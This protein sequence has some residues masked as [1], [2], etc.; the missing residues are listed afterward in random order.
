[1]KILSK[2]FFRQGVPVPAFTIRESEAKPEI[3][4]QMRK[5]DA[6][7]KAAIARARVLAGNGA[8]DALQ[9]LYISDDEIEL[10]MKRQRGEMF[11]SDESIVDARIEFLASSWLSAIS[12][13]W[14]FPDFDNAV[15]I[16]A[17]APEL[18][19]R[20]ERIYA[21]LQDDVTK[22]RPTVDLALNLFCNGPQERL[23]RR[24]RFRSDAPLIRSGMLRLLPDPALVEPPL[25]AQYLRVGERAAR[26]LLGDNSLDS[27]LASFCAYHASPAQ[28]AD[29]LRQSD[30]V[31]RLPAFAVGARDNGRPIRLLF[32]GPATSGKR[33]AAAALAQSG[34]QAL[35]TADLAR[36][37]AW[38]NEPAVIASLLA[39]EAALSNGLLYVS[40]LRCS[41]PEEEAGRLFVDGLL[42]SIETVILAAET[43]AI[44]A[45]IGNERFLEIV[46]ALPD[47]EA[48]HELW[49]SLT[50]DAGITVDAETSDTL[51]SNFVLAPEEIAAA[52]NFAR[53][54]LDWKI[55]A[56]AGLEKDAAAAELLSAA[57]R[58][59]G[60][61][62]AAL[63]SKVRPVH[64]WEDIVLPEDALQQLKEISARVRFGHQVME[65][66]GF[67]RKL[68]SGKGI[69][70]L[71]A[72][73]SGTGKTMAAEV[74]ANDLNLDLYRIDLS[75]VVSKYIGE[76]EQNLERI[77]N[78]A[79]R[80]NSVLLF[81]EADSLLGKR[82]AVHDAH[83][84]YAN[85]EISYLLQKM[86]QHEGITI[87]TTNLRGNIDD[88]FLR[89]LAFMVQF[90]FPEE[91]ARLKIWKCVWPRETAV[92][93]A[94][95]FAALANRFRLSGGNISNV[96]LSAA[97]LAAEQARPVGMADILRATQREYAKV[98]KNLSIAELNEVVH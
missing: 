55:T 45:V 3:L 36:S 40:G 75:R 52:V 72:G 59:S 92:D 34:G 70:A 48:R 60:G 94:V 12:E 19:L 2:S 54:Q 76:T 69:A 43:S 8:D 93:R 4:V 61:E 17:L 38:K 23:D 51:A 1:M 49:R 16:L 47:Y 89:R 87:L 9:G 5:L 90:P 88:A 84:R 28:P 20:Y 25:L 86:E 50:E 10:L 58:Q 68:S 31:Q 91:E 57:R 14:S 83:D 62:L 35:L 42:E 27:R 26:A 71:F 32:S 11:D 29:T 21:Y 7:L 67:G 85:M 22:R 24:L 95:D 66:G 79:V 39:Q 44:S 80:S 46:F 41:P 81:D 63:A 13:R 18:D 64:R 97:F 96:G 78:A 33:E 77:F 37:S 65:H 30:I 53:Q 98:G 74:I 15:L 6:L 82:S 56:P 73:P